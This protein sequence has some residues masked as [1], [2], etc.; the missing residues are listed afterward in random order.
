ME[1]AP[2][3]A[4]VPEKL[5][6]IYREL[7]Q[8][9]NR[10]YPSH[11]EN[12]SAYAR[13]VASILQQC[14]I[15]EENDCDR[16]PLSL[17]AAAP[18]CQQA[19]SDEPV[20]TLL[21]HEEGTSASY[22]LDPLSTLPLGEHSLY[23]KAQP[24]TLPAELALAAVRYAEEEGPSQPDRAYLELVAEYIERHSQP[25]AVP[26]GYTL[27][28]EELGDNKKMRHALFPLGTREEQD[29]HWRDV[30]EAATTKETTQ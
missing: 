26:N 24:S 4:V 27:V 29:A 3:P 7:I 8:A 5:R 1:Y 30:L 14:Y 16:D 28:P 19:K 18:E 6:Q 20:A 17:L 9:H 11:V 13:V 21:V 15:D 12:P 22:A 10:H 2:Q 25:A 23:L